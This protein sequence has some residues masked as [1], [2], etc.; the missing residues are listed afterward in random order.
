MSTKDAEA[1]ATT[2][3]VMFHRG[4]FKFTSATR[5]CEASPVD[6]LHIRYLAWLLL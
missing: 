1:E 2:D 5:V 6:L 4:L 3:E